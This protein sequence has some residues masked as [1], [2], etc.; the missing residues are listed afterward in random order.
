MMERGH[1]AQTGQVRGFPG[2]DMMGRD[3][4]KRLRGKAQV[5]GMARLIVEVD[6]EPPK[7]SIDGGD[8][9]ET[10]A[11]MHAVTSL[12]KLDQRLN[13]LT[14]DFSGRHQLFKLFFHNI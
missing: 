3:R 11:A 8:F 2:Q 1:L 14:A 12:G 10:P 4:P 5:H 7:H 9:S 13:V 6:G